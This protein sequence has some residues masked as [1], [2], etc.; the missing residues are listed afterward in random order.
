MFRIRKLE[1]IL[2]ELHGA[3]YFSQINLKERFNQI[4]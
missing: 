4:L 3:Q 1:D 2:T